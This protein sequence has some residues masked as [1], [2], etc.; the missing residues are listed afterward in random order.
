MDSQQQQQQQQREEA[1]LVRRPSPSPP[2]P[3]P[4]PLRR[5]RKGRMRGKGGPQNQLCTYR[6]VR[7]RTW[8]RW[9]AEIRGPR[10]GGGG[11][12]GG[13]AVAPRIWLG[14]FATAL[15]AARAYDAAA[16]CL[17]GDRA[18][19]NLAPPDR[20]PNPAPAPTPA[21]ESP[22]SSGSNSNSNS[23]STSDNCWNGD[24]GFGDDAEECITAFPGAEDLGFESFRND[25]WVFD[26]LQYT[27][28]E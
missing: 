20:H 5:S 23:M 3:P 4:P 15:D 24:C 19:L 18:R 22:S 27:T 6:G 2:P 13:G 17:Y 26:D 1:L 10:R 9:V 11:G 7:Q 12:G 28:G 25:A 8:G 21:P 14:T 16:L